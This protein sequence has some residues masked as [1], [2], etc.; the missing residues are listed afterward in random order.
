MLLTILSPPFPN[1]IYMGCGQSIVHFISSVISNE[2]QGAMI[3]M[4]GRTFKIPKSS[5]A[6]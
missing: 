4:F 3:V 6:K 5:I 1:L 2:S